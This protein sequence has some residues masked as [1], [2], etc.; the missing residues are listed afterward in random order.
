MQQNTYKKYIFF[1]HWSLSVVV[2]FFGFG[3]GGIGMSIG[4]SIGMNFNNLR[5]I[6]NLGNLGN[7]GKLGGRRN[8]LHGSHD[9]VALCQ[10]GFHKRLR[11]KPGSRNDVA[12]NTTRLGRQRVGAPT[13]TQ[14]ARV[15]AV[16]KHGALHLADKTL[17]DARRGAAVRHHAVETVN[18]ATDLGNVLLCRCR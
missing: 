6:I 5:L 2:V 14:Q 15:A 12:T 9:G 13:A 7:L 3:F 16:L 11:V 4:M 17:K 18:D 10:H 1:L 8:V